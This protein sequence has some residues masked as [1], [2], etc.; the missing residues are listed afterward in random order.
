M[1]EKLENKLE[2]ARSGKECYRSKFNRCIKECST[3][4]ADFDYKLATL[5]EKHQFKIDGLD[6]EIV[7]LRGEMQA[8]RAEY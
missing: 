2:S 1:I 7:G 3:I 8:L 4:N 5:K 6:S